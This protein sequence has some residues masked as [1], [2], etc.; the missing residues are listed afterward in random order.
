MAPSHS[1]L[2]GA[3]EWNGER[4]QQQG[5]S[6]ED[7]PLAMEALGF[8]R[9][10]ICALVAQS[11]DRRRSHDRSPTIMLGREGLTTP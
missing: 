7:F 6:Y 1:L 9:V 5:S 10:C 4:P 3:G 11:R 2:L 8:R